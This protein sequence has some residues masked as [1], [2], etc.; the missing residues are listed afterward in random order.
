MEESSTRDSEMN[1]NVDTGD[2]GE[3]STLA[4]LKPTT[5]AAVGL[6]AGNAAEL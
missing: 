3:E 5:A 4:L 6:E 2:D 1:E